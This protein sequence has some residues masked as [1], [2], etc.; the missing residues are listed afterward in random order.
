MP[1]VHLVVLAE[2]FYPYISGGALTRWRFC[3]LAADR[4]H[5]VTVFTP[6]E[7]D[8]S[9]RETVEGVEIIRPFRSKPPNFDTH[10]FVSLITRVLFAGPLLV[11]L[12]WWGRGESIDGV[13][14]ASHSLHWVAKLV[15]GAW[16]APLVTMVGYTPSLL[17]SFRPTPSFLRERFNFQFCM[18]EVVFCRT[19]KI[20]DL[21]AASCDA[22]VAVVHGILDA[23]RIRSVAAS[24]D[25]DE[26]RE[27]Y[28]L[29]TDAP[30]LAGVGRLVDIKNHEAALEL[31]ARGLD[32]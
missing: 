29:P 23:E 2:D 10:A 31:L 14:S 12:A 17:G 19:A 15:S 26:T 28:D 21:I 30:L 25:A 3:K 11:Y 20:R 16:T 7:R 1:H 32:N 22:D 13:H 9:R 8:T 6:R 27:Q 18:G 4:G 24:V 5:R